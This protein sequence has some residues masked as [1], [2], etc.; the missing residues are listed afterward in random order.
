MNTV[1]HLKMGPARS[2]TLQT[3]FLARYKLKAPLSSH[4]LK[5]N[6]NYL[7]SL[8]AIWFKPLQ[9]KYDTFWDTIRFL[10]VL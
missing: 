2:T 7:Q 4:L 10:T 5:P 1:S 3:E 8:W 9:L 6:K